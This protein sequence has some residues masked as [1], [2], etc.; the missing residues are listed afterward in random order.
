MENKKKCEYYKCNKEVNCRKG[1][2]FC[3]VLCKEK[4]KNMKKYWTKRAEIGYQEDLEKIRQYRE[5]EEKIKGA[6]KN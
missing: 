2:K 6:V 1:A 5:L 3:S 4:N